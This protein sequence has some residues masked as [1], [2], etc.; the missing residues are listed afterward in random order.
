MTIDG[1]RECVADRAHPFIAQAA[2]SIHENSD[3]HAL[4]RVEVDGADAWNRV[5]AGLEQHLA[6]QSSDGRGA[7]GDQRP[8]QPRNG[9][10]PTQHDDGPA[11]D[12]G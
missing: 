8:T 12:V 1:N 7:R 6:G 9:D 4:D 10:I 3:G 5:D 11:A 2:E